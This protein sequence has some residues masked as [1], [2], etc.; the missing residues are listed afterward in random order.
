[1]PA[2]TF[3]AI[4]PDGTTATRKSHT[5]HYTH[6]VAILT[7]PHAWM[8]DGVAYRSHDAAGPEGATWGPT[9][10]PATWRIENWCGRPDLAVKARNRLLNSG[11]VTD[12]ERVV[13][14]EVT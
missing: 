4:L 5:M 8:R 11:Y 7:A 1:M 10:E 9:G 12:A 2:T 14:V 3:T 6:A 13:I